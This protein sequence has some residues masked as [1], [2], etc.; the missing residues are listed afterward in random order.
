G[1]TGMAQARV[2]DG[3]QPRPNDRSVS[4]ANGCGQLGSARPHGPNLPLA[5]SEA[6]GWPR[7]N[8][9]SG[10]KGNIPPFFPCPL[11][12]AW[13]YLEHCPCHPLLAK[14][15]AHASPLGQKPYRNTK[16]QADRTPANWRWSAPLAGAGS[17]PQAGPG[18]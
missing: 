4:S 7:I 9:R 13:A 3:R 17:S 8:D 5:E 6:P 1:T 10:G 14:G 2:C 15:S 18:G 11:R 16:E 12:P